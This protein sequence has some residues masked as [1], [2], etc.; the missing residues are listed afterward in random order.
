MK[1]NKG[2]LDI[3]AKY[4]G[5]ISKIL[6]ASAVIG[7][8]IPPESGPITLPVFIGGLLGAVSFVIFSLTLLK[9]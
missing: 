9:R 7:F 3:L 4:F 1:L 5:D 2:Q 8:F 6:V